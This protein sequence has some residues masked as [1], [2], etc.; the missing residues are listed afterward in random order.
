[1]PITRDKGKPSRKL[2][3]R[4]SKEKKE[5]DKEEKDKKSST[6]KLKLKDN[7]KIDTYNPVDQSKTKSKTST[8]TIGATTV[9]SKSDTSNNKQTVSITINNPA[10]STKEA[11]DATAVKTQTDIEKAG[12][13]LKIAFKEF[14]DLLAKAESLKLTIPDDIKKISIEKGDV[15][16]VEKINKLILDL[17]TRSTKL[18]QMMGNA[19]GSTSTTARTAG[20]FGAASPYSFGSSRSAYGIT[21][22]QR[23]G[24]FQTNAYSTDYVQQPTS[25]YSPAQGALTSNYQ[26]EMMARLERERLARIAAQQHPAL[27]DGAINTQLAD[28][29][30]QTHTQTHPTG[31]L[32]LTPVGQLD[33]IITPETTLTQ[34]EL[35]AQEQANQPSG[36]NTTVG[37]GVINLQDPDLSDAFRERVRGSQ[38]AIEE[39]IAKHS[40]SAEGLQ[41]AYA[42]H[43]NDFE[44]YTK[45][46]TNPK[47]I[48]IGTHMVAT[49]R[50]VLSQLGEMIPPA[51]GE[52][53]EIDGDAT[54]VTVVDVVGT[55][56]PTYPLYPNEN[57]ENYPQLL[58]AFKKEVRGYR[59]DMF[60][61][62]LSDN[63]LN[64]SDLEK[65]TYLIQMN[66][67]S[68]DLNENA[69]REVDYDFLDKKSAPQLKA[70]L[71][72]LGSKTL[73][74][75]GSIPKNKLINAILKLLIEK[76][77]SSD[78]TLQPTVI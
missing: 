51:A 39:I 9:T 14:N 12:E 26:V 40:G 67:A 20:A 16:T 2:D 62:M 21:Q 10:S 64:M 70:I 29:E 65:G 35:E 38:G 53:E 59:H 52:E 60:N 18:T 57:A 23:A 77:A 72:A 4:E 44:N 5:K 68:K 73:I 43:V 58:L 15:D 46:L 11:T 61:F 78:V 41:L 30:N 48:A 31:G 71:K 7:A 25:Y 24:S 42:E 32:T 8:K 54:G 49:Y 13:Q 27:T 76:Q 63:W 47:E 36:G 37:E 3:L 22:D 50:K 34:L 45:T 74:G 66:V 69:I 1:M 28:L 19:S 6:T 56:P 75:S 33:T 55:R 17:K